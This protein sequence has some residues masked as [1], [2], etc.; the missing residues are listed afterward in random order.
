MTE[1]PL[2]PLSV[3][4][5]EDLEDAAQ[6][7]AELLTLCGHAVRVAVCGPDA[8][9]AVAAEV[10]DVVLL[11][12]GLPGMSGWEV[13][14]RLRRQATDKQP[15]VVAV[16]G[17]GSESDRWHSAD[18]GVDMHLTKPADPSALIGFL[19]WVRTNLAAHR[20]TPAGRLA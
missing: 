17:Y 16:T 19:A 11:D 7:T 2:P 8:L 14:E 20:A 5:V 1:E 4:V 15:V 12:I 10:P 13:A 18:A 3:L 6:S 9:A